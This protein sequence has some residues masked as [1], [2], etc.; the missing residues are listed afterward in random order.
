MEQELNEKVFLASLVR[1]AMELLFV[2]R[3][4]VSSNVS[5]GCACVKTSC[6]SKQA[7]L[8]GSPEA[9]I[10]VPVPWPPLHVEE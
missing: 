6:E 3:T 4:S 2:P 7:K 5:F 8:F 1:Q 9:F 10:S